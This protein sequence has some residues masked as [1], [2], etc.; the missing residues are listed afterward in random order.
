MRT[1]EQVCLC[2]WSRRATGILWAVGGDLGA[3]DNSSSASGLPDQG[4]QLGAQARLPT[5]ITVDMHTHRNQRDR[6]GHKDPPASTHRHTQTHGESPRRPFETDT[7]RETHAGQHM[8]MQSPY[9]QKCVYW[10]YVPTLDCLSVFLGY[11]PKTSPDWGLDQ[12]H[13]GGL[14]G[15]ALRSFWSRS[16]CPNC[17]NCPS[18]L[19]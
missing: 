4:P 19:G 13:S 18:V 17:C 10:A 11:L 2:K 6:H 15:A 1:H 5:E 12:A 9:T 16:K 8:D 14:L 7:S 3:G